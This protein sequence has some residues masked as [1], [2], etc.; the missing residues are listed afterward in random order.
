MDGNF[1]ELHVLIG[2]LRF[3][4]VFQRPLTELNYVIV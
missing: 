1:I 2:V 4:C 3:A